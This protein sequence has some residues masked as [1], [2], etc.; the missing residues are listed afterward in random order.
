MNL[1]AHVEGKITPILGELIPKNHHIIAR[2]SQNHHFFSKLQKTIKIEL[3]VAM[4]TDAR[5][6]PG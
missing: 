1:K 3:V 5:V 4:S 6:Y 2:S